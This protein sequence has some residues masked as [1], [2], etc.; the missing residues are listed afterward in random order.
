MNWD[1]KLS[2]FIKQTL[3]F[4][5]YAEVGNWW[6][7]K[8][9]NSPFS[10]LYIIL[11]GEAWVYINNTEYHL[12]PGKLFL[13]PKFTFHTYR[14]NTMMRNC[15]ICFFDEMVEG[16]GMYD[17]IQ[18]KNLVVAQLDDEKLFRRVNELNPDSFI[19]N[20]DPITYDNKDSI[21]S[22]SNKKETRSLS[23]IIE[24]QGILLQLTSR[25]V[26]ND[27]ELFHLQQSKLRFRKMI[28]YIEKNIDKKLSIEELAKQ[29][30]LSA[31]YF[32][33][34]FF[35]SMGIRPLEYIN[36]KRIERA[37]MLLI[38]TNLAIYQIS[39]KVGISNSSYF[40]AMFK[41]HTRLT[42]EQYQKLHRRI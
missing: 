1:Q 9:V 42:P 29:V 11:E 19:V 12:V 2:I 40:T 22:H 3:I 7:F 36:S 13:I 38:T 26:N 4:N 31:D 21:E 41:K 30:F 23:D 33:K 10:R 28:Y 24:T 32:S 6:N 20:P 27:N 18:F 34:V 37:Q 15:Y 35:D 14:C 16:F 8:E 5:D 17:I 25:F 39:D